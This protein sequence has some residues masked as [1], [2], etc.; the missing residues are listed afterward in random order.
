MLYGPGGAGKT[1]MVEAIASELGALVIN[2]SPSRL[3]G[4]FPGKTGPTKALHM[5]FEVAR[6]ASMAPVVIYIDECDQMFAAGGKKGK[7]GDKEGAG[8]FKK[9]IITY[10]NQA[11]QPEDRVIIVGCTSK[12]EAG[13]AKEFRNFFQKFL[14]LPAPDYASRLMLWHQFIRER[15]EQNAGSTNTSTITATTTAAFT[16]ASAMKSSLDHDHKHRDLRPI[17]STVDLSTLAHVS[18]GYT[19]GSIYRAVKTTLTPRRVHR[20]AKRPLL[21]AEF[22]GVLAQQQQLLKKNVQ[23][24]G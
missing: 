20:I 8:R 15:L 21:S 5:A 3:K 13:D 6:D 7:G 14:Y 4:L 23:V 12:P 24:R 11:L 17:G 18:E 9:D 2:L 1:M 16:A 22:L 19:A 10:K